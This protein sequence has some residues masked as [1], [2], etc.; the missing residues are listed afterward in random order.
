MEAIYSNYY[1]NFLYVDKYRFSKKWINNPN[2]V[3]YGLLRYVL[4]GNAI[5]GINDTEYV[6]GPDDVFYIPQGCTL[7]GRAV[8]EVVFI[9]VRF[10]GSMQYH[11]GEDMPKTL[12]DFP[13]LHNFRDEPQ[14]KGYFEE[15]YR[16]A[17]SKNN[18]KMLEIR[19]CLNLLWAAL[20]KLSPSNY[21]SDES[22]EA[23]RREMEASFDFQSVRNRAEKSAIQKSDPRISTLV[24]YIMTHPEENFTRQ[25]L[26]DMAGISVSTLR[27]LFREQT[28][29]TLFAFIKEIKM[30]NAARRLVITTDPIST[31]AYDLGYEGPSY[32][33]ECFKQIY[34]VSPQDYR[35]TSHEL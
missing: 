26:C 3:P 23:D 31:I 9:S 10:V 11:T 4:S 15:I 2:T 16:S 8:S 35:K 25:Q 1:P 24:D 32:F 6:V 34:G 19:G 27:R 30:V 17:L 22:L 12:W 18:F 13:N 14:I 5:F 21:D 33:S 20:A 28:G 7:S 29:K